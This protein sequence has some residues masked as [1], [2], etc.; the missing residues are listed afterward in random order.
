MGQEASGANANGTGKETTIKETSQ[1]ETS[2]PPSRRKAPPGGASGEGK[3]GTKDGTGKAKDPVADAWIKAYLALVYTANNLTVPVTLHE[4]Y[5]ILKKLS[6]VFPV[7]AVAACHLEMI[8]GQQA[9][10]QAEGVGV[11]LLAVR[12]THYYPKWLATQSA[13]VRHD[14]PDAGSTAGADDGWGESDFIRDYIESGRNDPNSPNYYAN[15]PEV[16]A[17]T[18]GGR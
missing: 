16:I 4:D 1:K 17:A 13:E 11:R 14:G 12:I 15:D 5:G 7:E 2:S 18:T 9:K 6:K 8:R 10:G 3:N